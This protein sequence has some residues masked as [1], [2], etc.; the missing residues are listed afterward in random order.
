MCVHACG[1]HVRDV[2]GVDP[3]A[4]SCPSGSRQDRFCLFSPVTCPR[5]DALSGNAYGMSEEIKDTFL[6][7]VALKL[8]LGLQSRLPRE[9]GGERGVGRGLD[10]HLE[11]HAASNF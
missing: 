8:R 2:W 10:R 4:F 5:Q 11:M 3:G 6:E 1:V 7:E 9:R